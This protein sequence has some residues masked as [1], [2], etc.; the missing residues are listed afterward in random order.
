MP[1]KFPPMRPYLILSNVRLLDDVIHLANRMRGGQEEEDRERD[2]VREMRAAE[3]TLQFEGNRLS[4]FP[5]FVSRG[6]FPS[7]QSKTE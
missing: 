4:Y 5:Q 3:E 1:Q 7:R 2:L 6:G